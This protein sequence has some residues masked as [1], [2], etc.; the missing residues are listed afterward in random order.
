MTQGE[1]ADRVQMNDSTG[2]DKPSTKVAFFAVF[3]LEF[4]VTAA[5]VTYVYIKRK[6]QESKSGK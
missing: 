6:E 5:L 1:P 3:T 4:A 2:T